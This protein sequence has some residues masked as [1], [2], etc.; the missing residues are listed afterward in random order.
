MG[1]DAPAGGAPTRLL[2]PLDRASLP[3]TD[4]EARAVGGQMYVLPSGGTE[5]QVLRR[6][7]MGIAWTDGALPTIANREG[8]VL[9][10]VN[11]RLAWVAPRSILPQLAT[12][13]PLAPSSAVRLAVPGL[14]NLNV[15]LGLVGAVNTLL[16]D[17]E[18]MRKQIN[19]LHADLR[20]KGYMLE[21]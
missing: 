6:V 20:A 3:L 1:S 4:E 17:N 7:G 18:A 13:A 15:V 19:D 21:G 12:R 2:V 14:L 8:Q 10:V 11:G 5:G 9:R 16:T